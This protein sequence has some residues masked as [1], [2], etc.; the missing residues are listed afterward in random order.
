MDQAPGLLLE[1]VCE[2]YRESSGKGLKSSQIQF[3]IVL[4]LG[5]FQLAPA[6]KGRIQLQLCFGEFLGEALYVCKT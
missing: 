5:V 3:A 6:L 2:C 4:P 1:S